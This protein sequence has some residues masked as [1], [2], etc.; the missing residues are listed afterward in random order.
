MKRIRETL[1]VNNQV[2]NTDYL[3]VLY[4]RIQP[5]TAEIKNQSGSNASGDQSTA[6][7]TGQKIF[8]TPFVDVKSTDK[9]EHESKVYEIKSY[10]K[11]QDAL[12]RAHHLEVII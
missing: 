10:Y 6:K 12:G 9:I 1:D 2:V 7:Y 4:M 8:F 11:V 3:N 5:I